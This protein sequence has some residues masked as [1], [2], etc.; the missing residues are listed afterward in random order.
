MFSAKKPPPVQGDGFNFHLRNGSSA[1]TGAANPWL[2]AI[3]VTLAAFMEVLD[4]TSEV[5]R[6]HS[7]WALTSSSPPM[8]YRGNDCNCR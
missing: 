5:G 8:Q 4:T 2:I 6:S 3:V 7:S 1:T